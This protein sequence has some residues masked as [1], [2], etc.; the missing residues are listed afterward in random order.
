MSHHGLMRMED[1]RPEDFDDI[2]ESTLEYHDAR[3]VRGDEVTAKL[4]VPLTHDEFAGL[5]VIA[6]CRDD[7]SIIGAARDAIREYVAAHA[8]QPAAPRRRAG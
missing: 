5:S 8:R 3:P 7:D 4:L 6:H 2:D 1:L